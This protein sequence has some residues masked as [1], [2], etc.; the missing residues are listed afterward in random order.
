MGWDERGNPRLETYLQVHEAPGEGSPQQPCWADPG[1]RGLGEGPGPKGTMW[2]RPAHTSPVTLLSLPAPGSPVS[3]PRGRWGALDVG[4]NVLNLCSWSPRGWRERTVANGPKSTFGNTL[5]VRSK[6]LLCQFS[7]FWVLWIFVLSCCISLYKSPLHPWG[8]DSCRSHSSPWRCSSEPGQ[9]SSLSATLQGIWVYLPSIGTSETK[10]L[11]EGHTPTQRPAP[12]ATS[13]NHKCEQDT[14]CLKSLQRLPQ[15]TWPH[16]NF[17]GKP[18]SFRDWLQPA[19]LN[20][21][22]PRAL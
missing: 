6:S 18:K 11:D 19:F 12:K 16:L 14:P 8:L 7:T 5:M 22:C 17:I 4:T 20:C 15:P 13:V 2:A 1:Y 9:V 21:S 3:T 10:L